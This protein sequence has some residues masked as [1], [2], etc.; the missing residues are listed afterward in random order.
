MIENILNVIGKILGITPAGSVVNNV[1][2][3]LSFL[4][5][6]PLLIY[7]LN[8]VDRQI[9]FSTSVGFLGLIIA[10]AFFVMEVLRRSNPNKNG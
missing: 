4:A 1:A 8:N 2:G 10:F 9:S 3:G 7:V 6:V 5:A